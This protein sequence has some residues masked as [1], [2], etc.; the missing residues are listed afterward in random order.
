MP[1]LTS[2]IHRDAIT[3]STDRLVMEGCTCHWLGL[4]HSMIN[5]KV[6]VHSDFS[7][8]PVTMIGNTLQREAQF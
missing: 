4:V 8:T 1:S 7:G 6:F 3:C 5:L 2:E